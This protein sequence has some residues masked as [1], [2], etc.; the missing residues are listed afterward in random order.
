MFRYIQIDCIRQ[1]STGFDLWEPVP[2]QVGKKNTP[3]SI[4]S[5]NL[6]FQ[7]DTTPS[8]PSSERPIALDLNEGNHVFPFSIPIPS[9]Y[10][11]VKPASGMSWFKGLFGAANTEETETLPLPPSTLSDKERTT[12]FLMG[13]RV[14]VAVETGLGANDF[15]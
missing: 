7:S 14:T 2:G 5:P 12:E 3:V 11:A 4:P 10:E 9:T 1:R 13:W 6:L 15:S 8:S